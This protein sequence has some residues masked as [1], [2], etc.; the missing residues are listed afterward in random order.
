MP[1]WAAI[2][3]TS[4]TPFIHAFFEAEKGWETPNLSSFYSYWVNQ[5]FQIEEDSKPGKTKYISGNFVSSVPLELLTNT[6][7]SNEIFDDEVKKL[8]QFVICFNP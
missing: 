8:T 4:T 3:A 5:F 7:I 2:I 6:T 1:L